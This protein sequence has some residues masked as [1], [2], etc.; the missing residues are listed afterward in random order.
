LRHVKTTL[1]FMADSMTFQNAMVFLSVAVVI[2]YFLNH[3][4][5]S[6]FA[7]PLLYKAGAAVSIWAF[8]AAWCMF[9]CFTGCYN[10]FFV[11]IYTKMVPLSQRGR[12]M[13]LGGA[14]ANIVAVLTNLLVGVLTREIA[15]Q[16]HRVYARPPVLFA[17]QRL[18]K[19]VQPIEVYRR[20]YLPQNMPLRHKTFCIHQFKYSAF[21][22]PAFQHL[23]ITTSYFNSHN[24]K[25]LPFRIDF[26]DR[27]QSAASVFQALAALYLIPFL[28][29]CCWIFTFN[30]NRAIIVREC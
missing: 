13:G 18:Y 30:N 5:A 8:L 12:V 20:V 10:T 15:F 22:F 16:Y 14:A 4:G 25:S 27:L 26:F 28:L 29:F 24:Q 11:A 9:N 2:P 21:H 7:I 23:Y 17:V 6:A 1:L 3:L 19:L